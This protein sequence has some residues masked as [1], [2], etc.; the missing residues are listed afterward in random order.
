MKAPFVV[1]L[2]PVIGG[3]GPHGFLLAYDPE[4]HDGR[5]HVEL[6]LDRTK[7]RVFQSAVE[8]WSTYHAVPKCHPV[9]ASDGRPN[10]P[11]T[12][13]HAET[14]PVDDDREPIMKG[15]AS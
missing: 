1:Y 12:A 8:F 14:V 3:A 6:T 15:L 7:A 5:G 4:A 9:R 11:L 10:R 2:A 13:F